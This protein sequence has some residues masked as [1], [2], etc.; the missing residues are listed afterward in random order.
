MGTGQAGRMTTKLLIDWS[1]WWKTV[2][3][4]NAVRR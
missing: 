1:N 2:P 4:P 3:V